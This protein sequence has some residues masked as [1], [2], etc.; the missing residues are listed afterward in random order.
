MSKP[1]L[2]YL[3]EYLHEMHNF[4]NL[5]EMYNFYQRDPQILRIQFSLL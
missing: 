5:Y 2:V 3:S 1:I 4:Y